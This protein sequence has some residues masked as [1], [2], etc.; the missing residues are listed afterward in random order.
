VKLLTP[1]DRSLDDLMVDIRQFV[2]DRDWGVFHRPTALAISAAIETGE[3]L[4]L[5]QW[6]S[7]AEVETS[8]QSD[9]YLQALSD[10]IAD[11]LIY[12]LRLADVVGI[13]PTEAVLN[14]MKENRAKYPAKEWRGR[15]PNKIR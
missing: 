11:V 13:N 6:R 5:F 1:E 14:K 12:L 4:E 9:K 8:L 3:L 15:A 2:E 10:E 7:D